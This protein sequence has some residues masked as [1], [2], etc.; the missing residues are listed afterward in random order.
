MR[1]AAAKTGHDTEIA[2]IGAGL[3]GGVLAILL[4]QAGFAVTLVEAREPTAATSAEP[5]PRALAV[6]PASR[7]I[8]EQAGIWSRLPAE[9]ISPFH[10]MQVWDA[11][12]HGEISF[13][14]DAVAEPALGYIIEASVLQAALEAAL[15]ADAELNWQRPAAVTALRYKPAYIELGLDNGASLRAQLAVGADGQQSHSRMLAGIS[16]NE[17]PYPQRALACVVNTERSHERIARQAFLQDSVLAFLPMADPQQCG[18]V[19]STAPEQAREL[20][21]LTE[22]GFAGVL[23]EAFGQRLGHITGVG[24]RGTF[25]LMKAEAERYIGDRFVLV[26]DAAHSIHPLAGQGANMGWLDAACLA[27]ILTEVRTRAQGAGEARRDPGGRR[28][29]RRYERWRRGENRIMQQTLDGLYHLFRR[30]EAPVRWLR[31]T[32][33]RLTDH[34]GLLKKL[35]MRHAMGRAGDLPA[36]ARRRCTPP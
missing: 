13:A 14:A 32:G 36:I 19:W 21:A 4:R 11:G 1:S 3:S 28:G 34:S 15:T 33:L 7:A 35:L 8:L 5:D 31:N 9:R 23:A 12:G 17:T 26:G 27:E 20:L 2:V 16:Y 25:P 22:A 24:R 18:I 30:E 29:L 6:T 10:G